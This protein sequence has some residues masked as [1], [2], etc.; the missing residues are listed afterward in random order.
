MG[1]AGIF[2]EDDRVELIDG[3][4]YVMSPIGSVSPAS[5]SAGPETTPFFAFRIRFGSTKRRSRGRKM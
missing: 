2:G 5:S 1:E 4:I 3:Q